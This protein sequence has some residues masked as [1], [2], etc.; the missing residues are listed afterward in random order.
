MLGI[1][2]AIGAANDWFDVDLDTLAKPGKPIP[3][4]LVSRRTALVVAVVCAVIGLGAVVAA[5]S[6]TG[7]AD[8]ARA[9]PV[10]LMILAIGLVYDAWLKR[11]VWGWL[12]FALAFPL[13]P[14]YAWYG[15]AAYA[16]PGSDLLL[17]VAFLA[18]PMLQ[19]A[20]GIVDVDSDAAAGVV[21]LAGGLGRRGAWLW[22]LLLQLVVNGLA[23]ATLFAD[24]SSALAA[25]GLAIGA[26][27]L[28]GMGVGLSRSGSA[29]RREWGW[30]CQ[31][32]GLA[33]LAVG[34]LLWRAA[35]E[36]PGG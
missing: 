36:M 31:A 34:W 7:W 35:P 6:L 10:A 20:N 32:V 13:L 29:A 5:G 11:T 18:G 33:L 15:A 3:A 4:G 21:G 23:V 25:R 9:L 26:A 8:G 19:L 22:L 12:A 14:L 1:Q 2:F 30:R 16:P 28:A 27:L 17:P 24:P